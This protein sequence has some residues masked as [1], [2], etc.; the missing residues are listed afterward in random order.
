LD[1]RGKQLGSQ[2]ED[3]EEVLERQQAEAE[4]LASQPERFVLL[5]FDLEIRMEQD[6]H[7]ILYDHGEWSCS[8]EF[9]RK[10]RTCCHIMAASLLLNGSSFA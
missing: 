8:C 1:F 5:A 4:I 3:I 7:L 10:N 2:L 9:F 6:N